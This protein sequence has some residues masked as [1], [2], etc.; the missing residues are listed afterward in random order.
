MG[1]RGT[2]PGGMIRL[3]VALFCLVSTLCTP[4]ALAEASDDDEMRTVRVQ[5][6]WRHQFQFAGF[7][8]AIDQGYYRDVGLNVQ[9]YERSDN[10][11]PIDQLLGGRVEFAVGDTG[12]LIYRSVGVPL[13]ALA[14][15]FQSSPSV[16][17]ALDDGD[18]QS[19]TDLQ[20]E[21]IMLSGGYMNAELV[22]MLANA[23][24]DDFE[25]VPTE[26]SLDPLTTKSVAAYN[27]YT[28]NEP[29]FLEQNGVPFKVFQPNDYG[30][31][32]YG[33]IVLTTESM[34][35][36]EPELTRHFLEAT[37]RGWAYAVAHPEK[38]VDLI[39]RE[40]N[41]TNKSREHLLFEANL[42]QQ[43]I[44]NN[45]V[46]IGYMN[47]ERWEHIESVFRAQGLLSGDV[48]LNEFIY[49]VDESGALLELFWHY[50]W[51]WML[52]GVLL[53]GITLLLHMRRLKSEVAIRTRQL[54]DAKQ[55]AEFEA[56]TDYLTN[57]PNR[58]HFLEC[59]ARYSAQSER[60]HLP[61]SLI[62]IDIDYFK[63]VNDRY[64]HAAGDEALRQ[65]GLLLSRLVRTGDMAARM[66]GEEFAIVC[67]STA[68]RDAVALAERLRQDITNEPIVH[69][70]Q[71][72]HITFSIGIA[73]YEQ[74][75]GIQALLQ[76][77][78][79]ALYEAKARGR[80][81]V[82]SDASSSADDSP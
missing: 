82:Y 39:L 8:A 20:G 13:V 32:F 15:I 49:Q 73:V 75:E 27:G 18:V 28:S 6:K 77:A 78:D 37:R 4:I 42:S 29:Y 51:Y 41:T 19:L 55:Q 23:G 9:L 68:A 57:L 60:H 64:G 40:Y 16:L 22:A 2:A 35:Q 67:M 44:L 81:T 5:L 26:T 58:R 63:K 76:K 65:V 80:N 54:S 11:Q 69:E 59:L 46:P 70:D 25:L 17:I 52:G 10:R 50:R 43:L 61:L 48:D 31:D 36:S 3:W 79:M 53:A 47:R 38:V 74:H 34:I 33:D 45:V 30:V 66:G 71:V 12:A 56:R 62:M 14:A 21:R 72:F 7:Y 1:D 24:V